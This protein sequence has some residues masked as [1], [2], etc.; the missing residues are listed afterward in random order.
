MKLKFR[1]RCLPCADKHVVFVRV[2]RFTGIADYTMIQ[3]YIEI[4]PTGVLNGHRQDL[5][6]ALLEK[7]AVF[8]AIPECQPK[9]IGVLRLQ[10]IHITPPILPLRID[11]AMRIGLHRLLPPM[12]L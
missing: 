2:Y 10:K 4:L 5:P 3:I 7:M 1:L 11:F 6:L 8:A 9:Q 12:N